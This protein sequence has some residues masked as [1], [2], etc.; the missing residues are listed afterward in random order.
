MSELDC[1]LIPHYRGPKVEASNAFFIYCRPSQ[2]ARIRHTC[3]YRESF[4]I[5]D[6]F[7]V[8]LFFLSYRYDSEGVRYTGCPQSPDDQVFHI[9]VLYFLPSFLL[10]FLFFNFFLFQ[11]HPSWYSILV[12]CLCSSCI[13]LDI[14]L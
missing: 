2:A 14:S 13:T 4:P 11:F 1:V 9:Y 7:L 8:S 12:C 5:F 3:N 6:V 10:F